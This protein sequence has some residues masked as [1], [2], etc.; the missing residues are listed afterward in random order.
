MRASKKTEF[1]QLY[2]EFAA[3]YP[4]TERGK[5]HI[6]S[7]AQNRIQGQENFQKVVAAAARGEDITDL[8]FLKWM[9][10]ADTI[11]NREKGVWIHHAPCVVGDLFKMSENAGNTVDWPEAAK[12]VFKF[13]K[14]CND[15]P[16]EL[17][18]ACQDYAASPHSKGLQTGFLTPILNALKPNEFLLVNSKSQQV[19]NYFTE[20][21]YTAKII[22]YPQIN[23]AGRQFVTSIAS[24]IRSIWDSELSDDDQFDIFC[25]WLKSIKKHNL[26]Q[27]RYW[28]IAP[29]E[30][31]WQWEECRDQGFIAIGWNGLGDISGLSKEDF[32]D[33]N[34]QVAKQLG[35]P[36]NG[37][38]KQVWNFSKINVGDRII[39]N[40]G[41]AEV[42]GIGTVTGPYYYKPDAEQYKHHLPV[43]WNDTATRDVKQLNFKW[44]STLIGLNT[45]EFEAIVQAPKIEQDSEV[46]MQP[47][48]KGQVEV[49]PECPFNITTFELLSKLHT[50]PKK[51][52]YDD[53]KQEFKDYLEE[54]FQRL[55]LDVAAQLP[56]P[57]AELMETRSRIFARILKNDWG[58]GGAW[59]FYWGAF[60]PKGGKRTEDAQ[61][62]LWMSY[63][64]LECGFYIGQ[65]GSEQ[66]QRFLENCRTYQAALSESLQPTLDRN[67]IVFGSRADTA[68]RA[69]G[70]AIN[71]TGIGFS[72]WI[73]DPNN[74]DIHVAAVLSQEQVLGKSKEELSTFIRE[75][76]EQVFP[77]V[78][79]ATL[80]DPMSQLQDY[81]EPA[82]DVS[83]TQLN[84][85]YTLAQCATDTFLDASRLQE[86]VNALN[87]KGQAVLY[88]PP[89]T[90]K[91]F[92]AEHLARH[93]LSKGDGFQ[94]L[95]QFHPAYTYEDFIQGIRPQQGKNGGLD[96]PLVPGRFFKFCEQ[97]RTRQDTCVLIID[98]INRANL[99]QVFGE[100]MY[101]L[102]Y[103]DKEVE[104]ASGKS[105]S[106]PKNVRII[107]TMNTADRSI[108]LVDHALRRRFAFLPLYPDMSIL[109][110]YHVSTDFA[111]EGLVQVLTDVNRAIGDRQYE[112]GTSFFLRE[113]L[114]SE[115]PAIWK[116][117]IE[118][119]LEEYF[120]DRPEQVKKFRWVT[121]RT[122]LQL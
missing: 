90:G 65:Y 16:G 68:F 26:Q 113:S 9:P 86:W 15:E 10:Y 19:L 94:T 100:L 81:L 77:L 59:D 112:I 80:E 89:G 5:E 49:S 69:D 47:A 92:L 18:K 28:K 14:C 44:V 54:P 55:M 121:I 57:I 105:F 48:N 56:A 117:E 96:Y 7:Y 41:Q 108:A 87:R 99:A 111:V 110:N 17:E 106:I 3:D 42:V 50:T 95:V 66:R 13:V 32:K 6:A 33:R 58:Q 122:Q 20:S 36:T 109:R 40:R 84:E 27:P 46:K 73:Q 76:F 91:T 4:L 85:V 97:A 114:S 102:E 24:E 11:S 75:T 116:M 115:L 74:S 2:Q 119:Y 103:R 53:H 79:L 25:H 93:L 1:I 120:F 61:L 51:T 23:N 29:G 63:E 38:Q 72:E 88:G 8:L 118:P 12:T 37:G 83:V 30:S 64:R 43:K 62:F 67:G 52:I 71:R 31:A 104:L 78:L 22:D 107:G 21:S 70:I 60:Y 34:Q 82:E 39:A 98:E 101:L 35:W 45:Q